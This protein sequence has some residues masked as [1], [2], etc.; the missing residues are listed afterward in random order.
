MEAT[1]LDRTC[2]PQKT[3]WL[4]LNILLPFNYSPING[5]LI[6]ELLC[7]QHVSDQPAVRGS[8]VALGAQAEGEGFS[9]L[10]SLPP[11]LKHWEA[12]PKWVRLISRLSLGSC[13]GFIWICWFKY[14]CRMLFN[15]SL[16]LLREHNEYFSL[17]SSSWGCIYQR[18]LC[19][20]CFISIRF[21]LTKELVL[22]L[23]FLG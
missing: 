16:W 4:T 13:L 17:R 5:G 15:M 8:L 21:N 9:R 3:S 23:R 2:L 14:S 10:L 22:F 18:V 1:S 20:F 11:C 19:T 12:Y 6:K 7:L